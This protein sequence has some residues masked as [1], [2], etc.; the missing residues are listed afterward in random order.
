MNMINMMTLFAPVILVAAVSAQ[1]NAGEWE[2]MC[3]SLATAAGTTM[4]A[5]QAGVPAT[6]LFELADS[7]DEEVRGL[8]RDII[9]KAY[10]TPRFKT[11]E[12]RQEA[13]T[14]F[15]NQTLVGCLKASPR[16]SKANSK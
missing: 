4:D 6:K 15:Q 10:D 9:L 2:E 5:R 7:F 3:D 12:Y 8:L 16:T 13:I 1:V 14:E 11:E